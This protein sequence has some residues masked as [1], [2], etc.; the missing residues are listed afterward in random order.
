MC[1]TPM[2]ARSL[3][4]Y[5]PFTKKSEELF[6][7]TTCEP[8]TFAK[9]GETPKCD[10]CAQEHHSNK[11]KLL[12]R[13]CDCCRPSTKPQNCDDVVLCNDCRMEHDNV[14]CKALQ[15]RKCANC[16]GKH[17][18][19]D[20]ACRH[21]AT[22]KMREDCR[23]AKKR[24]PSWFQ[25]VVASA[26]TTHRVISH[27]DALQ[28]NDAG[29]RPLS[30]SD[31]QPPNFGSKDND[32]SERLGDNLTQLRIQ[33]SA[34]PEPGDNSQSSAAISAV[35]EPKKP[36]QGQPSH[37]DSSSATNPAISAAQ[38]PQKKRGRPRKRKLSQ[39]GLA[40]PAVEQPKKL[41]PPEGRRRIF[42]AMS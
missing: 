36:E 6:N 14:N 25:R 4:S 15:E 35:Q 40:I 31:E 2:K 39:S 32:D 30:Q 7:S 27:R 16:G 33:E 22:L 19:K 13:R 18:A 17:G 37:N 38:Q 9:E 1:T 24:G 41:R 21:P 8:G 10:Q 42:K 28:V 23:D 3:T 29:H 20:I 34:D 11:C 5:S 26:Q 12:K